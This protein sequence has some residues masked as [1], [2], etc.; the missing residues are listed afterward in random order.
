M[1]IRE[2]TLN[3][4]ILLRPAT[5]LVCFTT[6]YSKQIEVCKEPKCS[7]MPWPCQGMNIGSATNRASGVVRQQ[8]QLQDV[9]GTLSALNYGVQH[10]HASVASAVN[11]RESSLLSKL[12]RSDHVETMLIHKVKGWLSNGS[13]GSLTKLND[14]KLMK[15]HVCCDPLEAHKGSRKYSIKVLY[16]P[17]HDLKVPQ[18]RWLAWLSKPWTRSLNIFEHLRHCSYW[19]VTM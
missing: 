3:C 16:R 15:F 13:N 8:L 17:K 2:P 11:I 6:V 5:G 1:F 19:L 12:T 18:D 10:R 7:S 9:S 14:M 4:L